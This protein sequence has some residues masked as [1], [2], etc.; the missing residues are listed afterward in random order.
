M[1]ETTI[2]WHDPNVNNDENTLFYYAYMR[3]ENVIRFSKF[4]ECFEYISENKNKY[5]IITSNT[6]GK[7][8]VEKINDLNNIL[9]IIIFCRDKRNPKE[10]SHDYS[11]ITDIIDSGSEL[12]QVIKDIHKKY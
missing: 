8:L 5:I 12:N 9:E 11:K 4:N 2:I 1:E 7:A 6:N 3:D 10:W